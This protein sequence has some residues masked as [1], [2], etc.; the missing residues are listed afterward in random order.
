MRCTRA[1]C[2]VDI[3]LSRTGACAAPDLARQNACV[4]FP[5]R[6]EV[7]PMPCRSAIALLLSAVVLPAAMAR[8]FVGQPDPPRLVPVTIHGSSSCSAEGLCLA[9]TVGLA[10]PAHP[11]AC[12]SGASL[13]AD[14]GEQI[15]WCYTLSN[16]GT[17]ALAWQTLTDTVH[18][19]VFSELQQSIG[20]GENFQFVALEVAGAVIDA[21]VVATWTGAPSRPTYTSNDSAPFDFIDASDG[22]PLDMIGGFVNSHSSAVQAPFPITYFGTTTD[23]LCVGKNGA[24]VVGLDVCGIPMTYAFPSSYVSNAIAP[25]W[26]GYADTGGTVYTKTI[27]TPGHRQFV[28]EWKDLSLSFPEMAGFTFETVFDEAS[29]TI[30]FQY[31]STGSGTGD[32]G[33][34]GEQ[35]VSGLQAD[36]STALQYSSFTPTLTPGKA[37]LW[38]PQIPAGVLSTTSSAHADVGAAQLILPVAELDASAAVGIHV[39]QPL[40]IG[41]GGNRTLTW[42]AGEYPGAQKLPSRAS[43]SR[44]PTDASTSGLRRPTDVPAGMNLAPRSI[45]GSFALPAY[46]VELSSTSMDY[47]TF[48]GFAPGNASTILGG[49]GPSDINFSGGDFV[50]N[51]FSRVWML[52]FYREQ[53]STLDTLTGELHLVGWSSPQRTVAGEAWWGTS[54][55]PTTGNY[56]AVSNNNTCTWSGLYSIDRTTAV[57]SFVGKIETGGNTCVVDIAVDQGGQMVGLDTSNDVLL[58]IDKT[59]GAAQVVGPLGVDAQYAQSLKFDRTTG[60][61]YWASYVDHFGGIATIDPVTG[62]ATPVAPIGAGVQIFALSIAKAGGDCTQPLDASWL[63][64]QTS[65]GSVAPGDPVQLA[66]V[67]FDATALAAGSYDATICVFSNDPSHRTSPAQVPVHF[68]VAPQEDAIFADGFEG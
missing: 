41:N 68:N 17:Q 11:E 54:W 50:D 43:V 45:R 29:G 4:L 16:T 46:G 42:S 58:S 61:L 65:T 12:P 33:D 10:D 3:S 56:Y 28:V 44:P 15:S 26:S 27:G 40:V 30:L 38:T 2:R 53:L 22:T 60:T 14:V 57:A 47:I 55:D 51:D 49:L 19:A 64:L 36:A 9:V 52:D 37:I 18:G 25:A 23:Q 1:G 59:S 6:T 63:S 62:T 32:F 20:P 35:A 24:I 66:M 5:A 7:D 8:S 48:D 39:T 34:A 31:E 67:D 13:V 21:D